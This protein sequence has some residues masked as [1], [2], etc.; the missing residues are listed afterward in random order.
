MADLTMCDRDE[1]PSRDEC[2]RHTAEPNPWRQSY[3]APPYAAIVGGKC[4]YFAL[5]RDDNDDGQGG[6]K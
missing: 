2:Y 4:E 5:R 3:F 1:C 6:A